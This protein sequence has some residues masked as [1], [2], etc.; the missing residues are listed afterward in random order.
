LAT[1]ICEIARLAKVAGA[2]EV[3][4]YGRGVRI[5]E[6]VETFG[7]FDRLDVFDILALADALGSAP[8]RSA[9]C[10]AAAPCGGAGGGGGGRRRRLSSRAITETS[11]AGFHDVIPSF[12]T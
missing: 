5:S 6:A 3:G 8:S 1:E 9:S 4:K 2:L 10:R 11:R 12:H 7:V